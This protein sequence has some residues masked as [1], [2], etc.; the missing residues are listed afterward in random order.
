MKRCD[1]CGELTFSYCRLL[2]WWLEHVFILVYLF[3]LLLKYCFIF[4]WFS[5]VIFLLY[6][7]TDSLIKWWAMNAIFLLTLLFGGHVQLW[8][9]RFRFIENVKF[10]KRRGL[11][12]GRWVVITCLLLQSFL[13]HFWRYL[14]DL[15]L[16]RRGRWWTFIA[17]SMW[18]LRR[19][20]A[21]FFF[22]VYIYLR[23]LILF[24]L[25]LLYNKLILEL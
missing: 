18:G 13:H 10:I 19:R 11:I 14:K 17:L 12:A 9:I 25:I 8:E 20:L 6:A 5:F 15:I 22:N 23:G 3:T 4:L 21:R 2:R 24:L 7:S 16:C 1:K